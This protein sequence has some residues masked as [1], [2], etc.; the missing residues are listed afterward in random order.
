MPYR[1]ITINDDEVEFSEGFT[2]LHKLSYEK[3][4]EGKGFRLDDVENT[5]KLI[6]EIRCE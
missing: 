1:K 3:I 2:E 6:E 5:I 4:L